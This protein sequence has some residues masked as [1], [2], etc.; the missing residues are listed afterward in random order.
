MPA[1]KVYFLGKTTFFSD[2]SP[3]DLTELAEDFVWEEYPP[4]SYIM[5][6][7]QESN[8]FYVL[9]EGKAQALISKEGQ[10]RWQVSLFEPGD[11]CGELAIFS[12]HSAPTSIECLEKCRLLVLDTEHFMLMLL[13]WPKLY[14]RFIEKL[15]KNLTKVNLGLWEAKH[16]E[17]L[18]SMLQLNQYEGKFYGVWGSVKTTKEIEKKLAEWTTSRESLLLTGE[19]GTGRQMFAWYL[20]KSLY[21]EKAPFVMIDGNRFEQDWGNLFADQIAFEN[22]IHFKSSNLLDIAEGGTLFIREIHHIPPHSQAMLA[23]VMKI[24]SGKCLVIGCLTEPPETSNQLVPELLEVFPQHYHITPLIQRKRDIPFIAQGVLEK[25]AKKHNRN[26]PTLSKEATKLLLSHNYRQ[27]NVTELIQVIERAFYLVDGDVINLEHIFF[28][29][30]AK[31]IGRSIDLLN[32]SWISNFLIKPS[33]LQRIRLSSMFIYLAILTM[34]LFIPKTNFAARIFALVWGLW[35]PALAILSPLIG[36]LWCTICPFSFIM[37]L[38]QRKWHLNKAVPDWLKKYDYLLITGL[39]LL[40]FWVEIVTQMRSN[41]TYTLILLL[42]LQASAIII[43]VLFTRHAWCRHICPLG[44]FIGMA[45]IG[46]LL[47]V[48]ADSTVCLNKCTTHN[49]YVGNKLPGCPMSQHLPFLDNNLNCKL[50]FNCVENCPNGAVSVNLRVPAQEVW[51]V[52]RVDQGFTIFIGTSLGVL[53]PI[54]YFEPFQ[55][56][57]PMADWLISFSI[58]YWG[59]ALLAGLLTWLIAKPFHTKAATL[60]IKLVLAVI[61]LIIAGHIIYQLHYLPGINNLLIGLGF[62]DA[63]D[64]TQVL[65][66]PASKIAEALASIIGTLLTVFTVSMVLSHRPNRKH[67]IKR[68][69]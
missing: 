67:S 60:R 65:F 32:W 50:C 69:H 39:F 35:W 44:G 38:V 7:G 8:R 33:I 56:L 46:S 58:A 22:S 5:I 63:A 61:P 48:R 34:L 23:E 19:R 14:N 64:N 17:S 10:R 26:T 27:G 11:T 12:G 42:V 1:E 4:G 45:S 21:G 18:R 36:R 2:L 29:P 31:K 53:I 51:H 25:L 43:G 52:V 15:S 3:H 54:N 55:H 41:P 57:W 6:Q 16:K 49:C 66:I 30:P 68:V 37:D 9:T 62:R 28:G 47:E 20:H 59:T 40:I 24:N 13:R